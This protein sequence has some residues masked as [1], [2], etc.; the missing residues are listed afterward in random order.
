MTQL[1]MLRRSFRKYHRW[2]A[3]VLALP[4]F[5]TLI[6]GVLE[7][8]SM[9]WSIHLISHDWLMKVHVGSIFKL[10][11]VY[12]TLNGLGLLGLIVTGLSMLLGRAKPKSPQA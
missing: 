7:S 12:S 3:L 4:L 2:L 11:K 8:L 6:T 9:A 1:A 5:L 10:G